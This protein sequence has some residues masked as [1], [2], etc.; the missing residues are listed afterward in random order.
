MLIIYLIIF[1][2][3]AN[4]EEKLIVAIKEAI[5]V[6]YRHIDCA[7]VYRNEHAVGKALKQAIEESNGE[8]KREDF[9]ITGKIWNTHHSRDM[10]GKCLQESLNNLRVDYLDLLLMHW[11]F[12][13]AENTDKEP[14]PFDDNG[15][16]RYSDIHYLET[17]KRMEELCREGKAKSIGVS[18]FNIE[19]IDDLWDKCEIKPVVNQF[20]VNVYN[21]NRDLIKHCQ[22]K[23]IIITAYAP[24]GA[25]D[26]AWM[27]PEDPVVLQNEIILRLAQK[28]NRTPAQIAIKFVLQQDLVVLVKS[29][30]PSRLHEN[31]NVN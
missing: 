6:G 11:P 18:N 7:W 22:N 19:Q 15:K 30:T 27:K 31:L 23:G 4:D 20:E 12:G 5:K 29:V 3:K 8:L 13:Y 14:F 10:V 25:N 16:M 28:Y 24:L 21:Q 17:Y 9:F 1:Y 2:Y 26:R